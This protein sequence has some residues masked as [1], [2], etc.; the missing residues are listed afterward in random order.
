[1]KSG[2]FIK[3]LQVSFPTIKGLLRVVDHISL[4]CPGNQTLV[5]LGESGCGK[6]IIAKSIIRILDPQARV[7]GKI[8]LNDLNL[9]KLKE[10]QMEKIRGTRICIIPQNPDLS[11]N[12]VINIQNQLVEPLIIHHLANRNQARNQILRILENLGFDNGKSILKLYPHQLSGGMKQRLL[13]AAALLTKPEVI[14]ADEPTKGLDRSTRE[15]I[16]NELIKAKQLEQVTLVLITHDLNLA[17]RLAD[18]MAVMYAGEIIE[19]SPVDSFFSNPRH[20][21]SRALLES[22]PEK[23]FHPI[24]GISPSLDQLPGGCRFHPRCPQRLG[25]CNRERPEIK[26][27][28][29]GKVKCHL[30]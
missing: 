19:T 7:S 4:E 15:I 22:S 9:L 10:I 14:I 18:Q 21:Y 6:S 20:P 1:M 29:R 28:D 27:L 3:N 25:F 11:L 30:Y 8:K 26:T 17:R 12:P 24:P 13:I 2:L 23:G 16:I 5:I